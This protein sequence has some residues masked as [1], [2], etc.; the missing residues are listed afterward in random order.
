M[1]LKIGTKIMAGYIIILIFLAVVT[2]F[3]YKGMESVETSYNKITDVNL[4]TI[5][6]IWEAQY[7][8]QELR[9]LTRAYLLYADAKYE[10]EFYN[11]DK[12]FKDQ[13]SELEKLGQTEES[14]KYITQLLEHHNNYFRE[15]TTIIN[16]LKSGQ[17]EKAMAHSAVA[18]PYA[19]A[20]DNTAREFSAFA[21]KAVGGWV[22]Q[23]QSKAAST[24]SN[25]VIIAVLAVILG[26]GIGI[27]LTRSIS[28]PVIA[29]TGVAK[30]VANG[31]LT[32][33]VPEI[34]TGDEIQE[35]G[36]SFATMVTNLRQILGKVN[37]ASLQVA[38]TAEEMS[39]SSEQNSSAAQ[40]I[41]KAI[42]EV[43]KGNNRIQQQPTRWRQEVVR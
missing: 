8:E 27:Y 5:V 2:F 21:N 43:A 7:Y 1:K 31:D 12:E 6:S 22:A 3:A 9:G 34:K 13:I 24:Q 14:K 11:T 33:P 28:K 10:K 40:Q 15:A 35:L 37:E 25:S 32:K 17:R 30:E 42:E 23:A 36:K 20:F 18:L 41:A 39:S 38:S 29:L 26:I 4:P 19:E 16:Y